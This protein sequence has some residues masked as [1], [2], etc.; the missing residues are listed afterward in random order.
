MK[1][2]IF[3]REDFL[4]FTPLREG[5]PCS[6]TTSVGNVLRRL[7]QPKNMM[8][9]AVM[10]KDIDHCLL[11]A[12]AILQGTIDSSEIY[13]TLGRIKERKELK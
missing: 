1:S 8:S 12:L 6:S 10:E 7:L 5:N 3:E 4:G 13:S 2:G 11:S 9:S